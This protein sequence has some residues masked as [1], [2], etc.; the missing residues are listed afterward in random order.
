M[1]ALRERG[2]GALWP[3]RKPTSKVHVSFGKG[4]SLLQAEFKGP[5]VINSPPRRQLF[6][7]RMAPHQAL[8]VDIWG[9]KSTSGKAAAAAA[10]RPAATRGNTVLGLTHNLYPGL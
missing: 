3:T 6:F 8:S 5:A 4:E 7:S 1:A 9:D 2:M 10:A